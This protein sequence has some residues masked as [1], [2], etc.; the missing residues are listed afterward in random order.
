M[1]E[2][3]QAPKTPVAIA[4]EEEPI[5]AKPELT[6]TGEA[7]REY[8][9]L[10]EAIGW[11]PGSLLEQNVR[12][13]LAENGICVFPYKKVERYLDSK[14]GKCENPYP[15][16][17][18]WIWRPLRPC[19][20]GMSRDVSGKCRNGSVVEKGPYYHGPI[21]PEVLLTVEKI[22]PEF[23]EIKFLVSDVLDPA[24]RFGDPFLALGAEGMNLLVIERWGEPSFRM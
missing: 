23:P 6:L 21:P 3:K 24:D 1:F 20:F 10:A 11:K 15:K 18:K 8:N 19:D 17:S 4:V 9:R 16:E 5:A 22:A 7:L 12:N 2:R 14:F 13:F